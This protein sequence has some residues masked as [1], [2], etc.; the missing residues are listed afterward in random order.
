[1]RRPLVLLSALLLGACTS[2]VDSAGDPEPADTAAA[3]DTDP[4]AMDGTLSLR[5]GIDEDYAAT[6]TEVPAGPFYGGIFHE[7][8]VTPTGVTDTAVS[9]EEFVVDLSLRA[10]GSLTDVL[11]TT[12]PLPVGKVYVLG[13]LDTDGNGTHTGPDQGDP[14]TRPG[15]THR[16]EVLGGADTE[17]DVVLDMLMP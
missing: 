13:Y 8:D 4:V 9:I 5:F 3:V 14:V 6:M 11:Y 10:D 17:A 15:T 2:G 7:E 16:D 1:M 12:G